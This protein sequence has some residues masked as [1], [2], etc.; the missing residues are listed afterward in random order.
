M[1]LPFGIGFAATSTVSGPI[2]SKIGGLVIN[3]LHCP[4]DRHAGT[5][6]MGILITAARR[7]ATGRSW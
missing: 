1:F 2:A 4:L 5:E 6:Q 7:P 3:L